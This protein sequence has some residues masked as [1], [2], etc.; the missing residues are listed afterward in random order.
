MG[1][2]FIP[3]NMNFNKVWKSL[4]VFSFLMGCLL[5]SSYGQFVAGSKAAGGGF[6]YYSETTLPPSGFEYNQSRFQLFVNGG[7]FF[8][9][10]LEA[11]LR[12]GFQSFASEQD[13]RLGTFKEAESS[14]EIG[15]Y[16]RAYYTITDVVGLFGEAGMRLGL[17][18]ELEGDRIRTFEMGVRPGVLLMVNENLGLEGKIGFIGYQRRASGDKQNFA[19]TREVQNVFRAGIDLSA[20]S[21]GFRLYLNE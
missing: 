6:G 2:N 21:F 13:S 18:G 16:A 4:T 15:P 1:T 10:N 14:F 5:T 3:K 19:D 20:V 12:I 9:E 7:Y 17:G 11:G 8:Q